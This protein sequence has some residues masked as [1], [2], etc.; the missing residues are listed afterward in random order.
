[1]KNYKNIKQPLALLRFE[2]ICF[3]RNHRLE[4]HTLAESLRVSAARPWGGTDAAGG[5]FFSARTIENWWYAAAKGGY[6]ALRG[7]AR[8]SDTE[9]SRTL[10]DATAAWLMEQVRQHADMH[11][12]VLLAQLRQ[13]PEMGSKLPS[14]SSIRRLLK[15]HSMD[16]RALQAGRLEHGPTKAFET[17]RPNLLWM[18]DYANGPTL[19]TL[20]RKATEDGPE[21]TRTFATFLC[22]IIDDHSRLIPHAAYYAAANTAGFLNSLKEAVVRRGLP[23]RLYTDQGK[24]FVNHHA[25][26][27]CANL[28]IHLIHARP[29]HAWSK[30]KVERVIQTIQ[31]DFEASLR[32][33][34]KPTSLEELNRHLAQWIEGKYHLRVHDSTRQ[35]PHERFNAMLA[36]RPIS[37][38]GGP[39]PL[40]PPQRTLE[41][42]G[43]E[44]DRLFYTTLKRV[45]RKNGIISINNRLIE[46]E[47][48][49][50][51][52]EIEVH[53]DPQLLLQIPP[54]GQ[55]GNSP[56]GSAE[57]KAAAEA[58]STIIIEIW[59]RGR[60]HSHGHPVD[61]HYNSE[62][63]R[64]R[65]RHQERR[66]SQGPT[67]DADHNDE[68]KDT[69]F[70][71]E[72]PY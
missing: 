7:Q 36:P 54:C 63:H 26:H 59:H 37:P 33:H 30:G 22:V 39:M 43:P 51:A 68:A 56:E 61:L 1:M 31:K 41:Q 23:H 55:P 42:Q 34:P 47:L 40:H 65:S 46:V 9:H 17:D 67:D 69:P 5:Q 24:P 71:D 25:R 14:D 38:H 48:S 27:V 70:N 49:L 32:F 45:V 66:S 3:I 53:Y 8:R 19:Q 62:H 12:T 20:V 35:T 10:D 50:R 21:K 64:S 58:S 18:I 16:R 72:T 60:F 28:G 11:L 44:L 13:H 57:A 29:Y 15:A 52:Q 2:I 6:E 4:G